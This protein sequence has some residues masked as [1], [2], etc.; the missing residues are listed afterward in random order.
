[1]TV[2]TNSLFRA[3]GAWSVFV[4]VGDTVHRRAVKVGER[5]EQMAE[6]LEGLS[7]GDTVVAYPGE[8]LVDGA[9]VSQ[10]SEVNR[11]R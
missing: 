11:L 10:R 2:P 5:N 8:T 4:V 7:P 3:D 6:V 1:M 9:K